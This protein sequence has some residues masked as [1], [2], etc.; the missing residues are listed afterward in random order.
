MRGLGAT[1]PDVEHGRRYRS[2]SKATTTPRW[3]LEASSGCGRGE[4]SLRVVAGSARTDSA[5]APG[6]L[7]TSEPGPATAGQ[8]QCQSAGPRDCIHL[9]TGTQADESYATFSITCTRSTAR[10]HPRP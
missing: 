4:R 6:R 3:P 7:W 9:P 2:L 1:D 10:S 5:Y 8:L